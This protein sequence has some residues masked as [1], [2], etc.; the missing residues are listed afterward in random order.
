MKSV[1]F[2]FA[3]IF[4]LSGH[5]SS[6]SDEI[7][8]SESNLGHK[9]THV[10]LDEM[11]VNEAK[12]TICHYPPGNPSNVQTISISESAWPAHEA[13][14]D[15]R[16]ACEGDDPIV[17]DFKT[18]D[19]LSSGQHLFE[20]SS[21]TTNGNVIHSL[22]APNLFQSGTAIFDF[23]EGQLIHDEDGALVYGTL[24]LSS[25]GGSLNNTEWTLY[26]S[27]DPTDIVDPKIEIGQEEK[28]YETWVYYVLN[29]TETFLY[30]TS[31]TSNSV[32]LTPRGNPFQIGIG[33]GNKD[34]NEFSASAWFNWEFDGR[35]GVG[36]IN[37]NIEDL[38]PVAEAVRPVLECVEYN[39]SND[40]Y[41][42][43]FGYLN[44]N[45]EAVVIPIGG[46]NKFTPSPIDR[47]QPIW[48]QPGRQVDVF[49]VDF[50]GNNLVW[51]LASPNGSRRTST[52]S[53]N[54]AQRCDD[55]RC[56]P[57]DIDGG[58]IV[59]NGP[60]DPQGT[61]IIENTELPTSTFG[62]VD[63]EYIWMQSEVNAPNT[64]GNPHWS[65][66]A[67]SENLTD[68]EVS[69]LTQTMY[70]IRCARVA[71]CEMYWGET[72]TVEIEVDPCQPGDIDGGSIVFNG[73]YDPQ[74]T[75]IIENTELPTS[76]FGSVDFE[77]IWM[78]SEVNAPNTPGNPHW[79]P[80]AG[81]ENL[82]DLEVSGLTQTMYFIRCA[83]VAG[84]EM[85]WGE[86]N[87]VEIE[88]DP[89]QPGDID[90][91]SIVF[92]GPYDPQG[93]NIIE[94]TELPTS[95]FGSA[96]F[97]YIW[98]QSE[99]NA[100]NTPG[101]AHWSPIAGSENLTDL[102]VSGLTQTMYFI[103]CAR[104]AGCEMY[105]GETNTV[106]IEVDPC[107]PGDID[108]GSIVF[109]GPYDPQGTNIIENTE[110]PTSTFGSVDF[111]Y[112]WMQS[113]VNAPNTPG[114]PHWSPITGSENLTDLEI[115]GLTQ[116]MY[117]IRCARVA[118]CEMYWGETNTV[119]IEVDPCQPGDIDGG[120]IVF[121]GPYDPQGTNIIENTE[122]P[123]S[124]FGSVNFEY[125]WM[126]SEVNA[127]NTPGNPHWSPIAGSENLTDLEV[128]GLTQTM[129]FIRCA[130][131]AGCEMYWGE[132]NTV[133]VEV[134]DRPTATISGGGEICPE[135]TATVSIALTGT[136]PF[137]V[138]YSNGVENTEVIVSTLQYDFEASAGVYSLVSVHDSH[139]TGTVS[140][141]ASVS[142][143]DTPTATISGNATVCNDEN[144]IISVALTG[145]APWTF[146]Y[147][148]GSIETE[149]TSTENMATFEAGIGS[150]SLV[151]VVDANC[152]GSTTGTAF[153]TGSALPSATIS[154]T[155]SICPGETSTVSIALTGS[156]PWNI[157]YTD[158]TTE[159]EVTSSDENFTFEAAA[160]VY[161]LVSVSDANCEGNISGEANVTNYTTP[162]ANLSGTTSICQDETAT[163]IIDLTGTAPWSIT[164][165]DGT[166]ETTV[167]SAT[168]LYTFEANAGTY[169]L[170]S[171][172][173][174]NCNG[175]TAGI[176]TIS[177]F[178]TPTATISGGGNVC[179]GESAQL[180]IDLTGTA[181]WSIT[182]TDGTTE[183]TVSSSTNVY[184]F[185][186]G[187]GTYSLVSVDDA[188]CSGEAVGNVTVS[189]FEAPTASIS[190]GGNVCGGESAQLSID[191]T[192][193]APWSITYTDGTSETT[194]SSS[195]NVYS[196]AAGPG[197][198]N[199]VSVEDANCS[200]EAVGNVTV[201]TFEAPTA[202]ISG[203]GNVCE[204][205]SAQLS[206]DLTGTAPWSITYT[207]GTTE[208]TVSSS[209]N[210][211][212]FVAGTGT[213][214]LVSVDDANC[215]GEA[216]G[217]V[218]VSTFEAP[219]ASI[220]GGG[221]VCEGESAQLS[222]D[223]TGTA[224]WSITYTDGTTE[225]SV[226][227][228]TDVYSFAAGP[229][230]YNLVSVNDANCSGE[231]VGNATI[232]TLEAP[233]ATISGGGN[234]CE[235]QTASI[236]FSFTGTAPFNFTYS[237]GVTNFTET[238]SS[239]IF[240]IDV[241]LSGTYTLVSISDADCSGSVSGS[242][243]VS[244]AG[245]LEGEITL[246]ATSCLGETL[247]I[248]SSINGDTYSWS[249]NGSGRLD[250]VDQPVATYSPNA[251]DGIVEFT[252]VVSNTCSS[253]TRTASTEF[254]NATANFEITPDPGRNPYLT[255]VEYTFTPNDLGADAYAW[256]LGDGNT[257]TAM[258]PLHT[259][260]LAGT[261]DIELVVNK[262]GCSARF[263]K[264]ISVE[265]NTNLFIP[266]VIS[267]TSTNPEN[268]RVKIY[269]ESIS[270]DKFRFEI[271]NRWGLLVYETTDLLEA[272][273]VGWDGKSNNEEKDNNVFT[274]I[275][276]GEYITGKEF[277]RTGTIT[278]V[279]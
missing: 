114:N 59:F 170:V 261:K 135:E 164:Y 50:D 119:E 25:G 44:E 205:E 128:S 142:Y 86:T 154:G 138:V 260:T 94:N 143:L 200:G 109:N 39:P 97:E 272:Q 76:T 58:S 4:V 15:T 70:F 139:F 246:N 171:I 6:Y 195:T 211:Y 279:K 223:L 220:S 91:G 52:A 229:G 278:L 228:S 189:T 198:Y 174:A 152:E 167:S 26:M 151:S 268:S 66:V 148:D 54:P 203:G 149:A 266:N 178:D 23:T 129:Y 27:Y 81:S 159:T 101:N 166:T 130:R 82:T 236:N 1:G 162:T 215:S 116:T 103:R 117:F 123:T 47:G 64:P 156:A 235:G 115:S 243:N 83:R 158:G 207:D 13:H 3:L 107:Q 199:L 136:G 222:I 42:A 271:Y 276:R 251:R 241:S 161:S 193:T 46:D 75:N 71:G 202:S 192:G 12:I 179:E 190:G 163:V 127:P 63:F 270:N 224:P 98:M 254:I 265:S 95:T 218:T 100:P 175:E 43:H 196:F 264:R 18:C 209:T 173:D 61:N 55:N 248:S 88:V 256:N 126:Q 240:S 106:E 21:S 219:T 78:Q 141:E 144:A 104:V 110:L 132:T 28:L 14:G 93:T 35:T 118:G 51:T 150:Y 69:G 168:N 49:T 96:D 250:N 210:V 221:N 188:N 145:T 89:C 253:I 245:G 122:L 124:T 242:A 37:I 274:Y 213:Y 165:T 234:I 177:T 237:D 33:A 72:N 212:S 204:G 53:D 41:T 155:A 113:E 137:T 111:E 8:T 233:T 160:G 79:S 197:T 214:S 120:S 277:E 275:V 252:V 57:G 255:D 157:I 45:D 133:E 180:S 121:N 225:T 169:S 30:Q 32:T 262:Q 112:I 20:A 10:D 16:G 273:S 147:T 140:G 105:W 92:N 216:V 80:V 267:P 244:F 217:N 19:D 176:A 187:T 125:I 11:N 194:V 259:F 60:Y 108:G 191:L 206:I 77:Y 232:S 48:F 36:D 183:T 257:S 99:V 5:I 184:S 7:L 208:T 146:V 263:V 62:S 56:E 24:N 230:T 17:L 31:N 247:S 29:S 84:C 131:V 22:W 185:A 226:S 68:L 38:C 181:P 90:G 182:Y 231:A 74:G 67:G 239:T 9:I 172:E 227:S 73:P 238:S 258:I 34:V 249:T 85:Y 2:I 153:V 102:E 65:P 87:T 186:A 134:P 269:G 201:S 40:I